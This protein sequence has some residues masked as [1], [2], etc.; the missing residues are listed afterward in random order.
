MKIMKIWILIVFSV[1]L[2][3]NEHYIFVVD[4]SGSMEGKP[5]L[6]AK[7]AIMKT[8]KPLLLNGGKISIIVGKNDCKSKPLLKSKFVDNLNDLR[9]IV[10]NITLDSNGDNIT[11][12]FK[13][14]QNE[15]IQNG[16]DGHIYLF[17]DCDGI[18]HCE[19]I[20][21]QAKKL[22]KTNKLI[23]FTYLFVNGCD[24]EEKNNWNKMVAS[25]DGAKAGAAA[26]FDYGKIV[27]KKRKKIEINK[28]YFSKPSFVNKDASKNNGDNYRS[29]PWRCI[30]SDGLL[31]LVIDKK[32]Q[33]IDFFLKEPKTNA[34]YKKTNNNILINDFIAFLNSKSTC[35]R[36]DWRLSD[37]FELSRLTQ[38]G[39]N[40]RNKLFPYIKI[41]PHIS[42]TSAKYTGYRKGIDLSNGEIYGYRE[43]RPYATMFVAGDLDKNLFEPPI[44]FLIRYKVTNKTIT[45]PK[46]KVV[47]DDI[48]D[49]IFF[50]QVNDVNPNQW[51]KSNTVTIHGIN[52]P[53]AIEIANG[54]FRIN[55]GG[56]SNVKSVVN[57]GDTLQV[58]HMSAVSEG[59]LSKSQISIGVKSVMFISKT[60]KRTLKKGDFMDAIGGLS[61]D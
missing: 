61:D 50:S 28:Q 46:P 11:L 1:V 51:V 7:D 47:K 39:P 26:S 54:E 17:G 20:E 16:Y 14:A 52:I 10:N 40:R 43:D 22:A 6:E 23:P 48:I 5:I 27:Q 13:Y 31:W 36:N 19:S 55:G 41:W 33:D 9:D 53:V 3:A 18:N 8:A 24:D 59:S 37:I 34:F 35:G 29:K 30:D 12:G 44:E 58:R 49:D 25:I 57:D 4:G 38:I 42:V 56:W 2:S 45:N 32:E 60:K 15:M 21:A